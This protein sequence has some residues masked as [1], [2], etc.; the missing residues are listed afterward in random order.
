MI[1]DEENREFNNGQIR[2]LKHFILMFE[3]LLSKEKIAR[4]QLLFNLKL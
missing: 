3:K 4:V 2:E 1:V